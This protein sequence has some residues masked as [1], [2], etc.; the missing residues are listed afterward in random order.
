MQPQ[1]TN[2]RL[3]SS[4]DGSRILVVEDSEMLR[5]LLVLGFRKAGFDVLAVENG[6][7]GLA[8]VRDWSPHLI[9]LDLYLPKMD[10]LTFLQQLDS[11][12][13]PTIILTGSQDEHHKL[14]AQNL[15]AVAFV[16]KPIKFPALMDVVNKHLTG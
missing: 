9:V 16:E 14:N 6:E 1:T 10:G 12:A 3:N 5:N 8:A 13:T 2:F 4:A 7:D 15:G 11:P